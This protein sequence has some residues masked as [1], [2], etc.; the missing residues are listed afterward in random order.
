MT[1]T[2]SNKTHYFQCFEKLS[3]YP[4]LKEAVEELAEV[5]EESSRPELAKKAIKYYEDYKDDR[6]KCV[7]MIWTSSLKMTR[8]INCAIV[9]DVATTYGYEKEKFTYYF[10]VI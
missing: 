8:I 9:V 1:Q 3:K 4:D 5:C 7:T 10:N 2:C 6:A